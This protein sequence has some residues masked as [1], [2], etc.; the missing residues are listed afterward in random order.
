M[1]RY[2]PRW[3]AATRS[4]GRGHGWEVRPNWRRTQTAWEEVSEAATATAADDAAPDVT[5]WSEIKV[6]RAEDARRKYLQRATNLWGSPQEYLE[7]LRLESLETP[8]L[9]ES[10]ALM[11]AGQC[12]S[13]RQRLHDERRIAKYDAKADK[14]VRDSYGF[15]AA[16]PPLSARYTILD[17]C[18]QRVLLQPEGTPPRLDRAAAWPSHR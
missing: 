10:V 12:S 8:V 2:D 17:I 9:W 14:Q 6:S 16:P 4:K 5:A 11:F 1:V 13:Y 3:G 7:Y 15:R 18:T